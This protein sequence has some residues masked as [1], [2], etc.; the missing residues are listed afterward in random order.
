MTTQ[1]GFMG[2]IAGLLVLMLLAGM[3]GLQAAVP[4]EHSTDLARVSEITGFDA[5][6]EADG[7][8]CRFDEQFSLYLCQPQRDATSPPLPASSGRAAVMAR[9]S[10]L[11]GVL[12]IPNSSAQTLMVFDAQT[13][14]LIDER[15]IEFELEETG[16]PIH[17]LIGP[18]GT[19]LVSDQIRN[20]V[21]EYTLAGDYLGVFAPADGEDTSIM[22]NIRGMALRPNGHLLVSVGGGGNANAI[23]EF[24]L[25]G[26]FVGNFIAN[27]SGGLNSPFDVYQ[28]GE[29]DWLVSSINSNQVLSYALNN[30]A[31]N[32]V[33]APISSFPQQIVQTESGN[34]LVA[35]FSG[36][37]GV[38]E[39]TAGGELVGVYNPP[40]VSG[41]RGVYPLPNGNILTSS[42]GGVFEIDRNGNLVETHY[43]GVGRFI[44]FVRGGRIFRDRFE[45]E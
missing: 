38:H 19:V 25:D 30:G 11:A 23:A 7:E 4:E 31:S 43:A 21:H 40:G 10:D 28:R 16:T 34:V 22:Q 35:N 13:G 36:T 29:V 5:R 24:D 20:V 32:G 8:G 2:A 41:N 9:L 45:E 44:Q 42:G 26:E 12:F 15:F 3:S 39:F 17:A 6:R 33:F 18:A 27:G 1:R 37:I 14:E